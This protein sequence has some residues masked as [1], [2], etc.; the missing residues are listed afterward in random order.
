MPKQRVLKKMLYSL[1]RKPITPEQFAKL[2]GFFFVTGSYV[3]LDNQVRSSDYIYQAI[4]DRQKF[5]RERKDFAGSGIE[6][7][8]GGFCHCCHS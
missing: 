4:V 3:P 7:G 1:D 2:N 8:K 5:P 6:C